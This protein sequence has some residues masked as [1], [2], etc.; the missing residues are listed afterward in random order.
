MTTAKPEAV[1]RHGRSAPRERPQPSLLSRRER[2][3]RRLPLLPALI[4]VIVIT[5]IPFVVTLYYSFQH[6]NLLQPGSRHFV[7]LG[8]Y[9][10]VFTDSQ[11]R[12]AVLTTVW[13]TG[14]TVV[15]A[16]V[17]G[18]GLA[19]ILDRRFFG[20]GLVRTLLITPFL[21]M[22]AASALLWKYTMF[23]PTYGMINV[24]LKPFGIHG[25]AWVAKHPLGT[26][27]TVGVW[28]WTPFMMLIVLAGLQSQGQEILEAARVDGAS[29]FSIFREI[30]LPHL[31][32]YIELGIL[33][34][35]IYVV[36]TF[37]SIFM[38]TQGGP[39]DATTNLPYFLY[40]EAFRAFDIGVAAALGVVTVIG[41]IVIAMIALRMISTI[42]TLE[43]ARV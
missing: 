40:L 25:V 2:W 6:W 27:I 3:A 7:G 11:F 42:F 15:V 43:E 19:T 26:I 8:N 23:D 36:N 37:D 5:Q 18:V 35:S 34:G 20:R 13:I 4:Y 38:M 21:I 33:L 9:S 30:T 14:G 16:M 29:A 31:R 1:V 12:D 32:P 41:T 39:G 22:P 28:Q 17:L 10:L 24:F